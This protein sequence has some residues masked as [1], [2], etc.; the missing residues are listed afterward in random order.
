MERTTQA[1][2][3]SRRRRRSW[4]SA[5]RRRWGCASRWRRACRSAGRR[6]GRRSRGVRVRVSLYREKVVVD[7]I[8]FRFQ[9]ASRRVPSPSTPPSALLHHCAAFTIASFAFENAPTSA[10]NCI[11]SCVTYA[12]RCSTSA[13]SDTSAAR[14]VG[15]WS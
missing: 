10:N 12:S 4:T 3:S 8:S 1:R 13:I 9:I 11:R 14:A 6:G 5:R 15:G 2:S 7:L